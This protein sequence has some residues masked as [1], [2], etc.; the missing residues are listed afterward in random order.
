MLQKHQIIISMTQS[1]SPYDNAVAERVNGILKTEL[2]LHKTFKNYSQAVSVVHHAIDAYNRLRPHM[3]ISNLTPEQAHHST[4][5]L[6]KK[7][8]SKSYCKVKSV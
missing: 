3:S 8:K 4:E 5:K 7:W 1:G 2:Q 6:H